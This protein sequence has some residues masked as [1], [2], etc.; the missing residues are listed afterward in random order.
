[1]VFQVN[2]RQENKSYSVTSG[3]S[4]WLLTYMTTFYALINTIIIKKEN[5][6]PIISSPMSVQRTNITQIIENREE[7][8]TK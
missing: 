8:V 4:F 1:M 7:K 2:G 5:C 3:V 6:A